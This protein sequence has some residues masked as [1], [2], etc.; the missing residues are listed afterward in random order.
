VVEWCKQKFNVFPRPAWIQISTGG[1]HTRF[2]SN[3]VFS[4]GE[5]DPWRVGSVG[6]SNSD[7]VIVMVLE[8][9]AHHQDLRFADEL[10]SDQVRAGREIEKQFVRKWLESGHSG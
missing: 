4:D 10:D 2:L 8:G 7:S 9:G 5:K 1:N 3:V 6:T